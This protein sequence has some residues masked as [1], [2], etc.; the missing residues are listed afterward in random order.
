M[1][2]AALLV[3]LP[4]DLAQLGGP[5]LGAL[6]GLLDLPLD[7][8]DLGLVFLL[9]FRSLFLERGLELLGGSNTWNF[10]GWTS[11]QGRRW[12]SITIQTVASSIAID[13]IAKIRCRIGCGR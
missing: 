9:L 10:G 11:F 3:Q 8:G 6:L 1:H 12:S 13:V 2:L 5:L 7:L 4:I